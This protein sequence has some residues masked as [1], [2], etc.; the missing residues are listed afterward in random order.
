MRGQRTALG[1]SGSGIGRRDHYVCGL[2]IPNGSFADVRALLG[3]NDEGIRT[4]VNSI[5]AQVE[6]PETGQLENKYFEYQD[7][8][9]PGMITAGE[10]HGYEEIGIKAARLAI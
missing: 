6:N 7:L 3:Q 8:E 2:V 5:G 9:L 10:R 1:A 4:M